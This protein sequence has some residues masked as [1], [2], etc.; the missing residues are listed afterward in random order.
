MLLKYTCFLI[1]SFY[2]EGLDPTEFAKEMQ[3]KI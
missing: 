2:L 3:E 1:Q